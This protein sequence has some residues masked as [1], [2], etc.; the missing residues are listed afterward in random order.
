MQKRFVFIHRVIPSLMVITSSL[1]FY[2]LAQ[3]SYTVHHRDFIAEQLAQYDDSKTR[4]YMPRPNVVTDPMIAYQSDLMG[5]YGAKPV[6]FY[7]KEAPRAI[8]R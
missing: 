4:P 8:S 5:L 1:G 3:Y 2:W 7:K 6:V